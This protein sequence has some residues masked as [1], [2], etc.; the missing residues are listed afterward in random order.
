MTVTL[1][2]SDCIKSTRTSNLAFLN[3]QLILATWSELFFMNLLMLLLL[4]EIMTCFLDGPLVVIWICSLGLEELETILWIWLTFWV[5]NVGKMS[6]IL[7]TSVV[8]F[9]SLDV[10][11]LN[12]FE[13]CAYDLLVLLGPSTG[14]LF[15]KYLEIWLISFYNLAGIGGGILLMLA[16]VGLFTDLLLRFV[17]GIILGVSLSKIFCLR[18]LLFLSAINKSYLNW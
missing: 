5:F 4:I 9:A 13:A 12:C 7:M 10:C 3:N 11:T 17:S 2:A 15:L 16:G 8:L 18:D 14:L 6:L 1:D